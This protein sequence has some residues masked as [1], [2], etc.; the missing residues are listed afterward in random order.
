[1]IV[2][3]LRARR[4]VLGAVTLAR[5][6]PHPALTGDELTLVEDLVHRVALSVDKARLHRETEHIAERL[7][8]SLLPDLPKVDHLTM[9]ARYTP[10]HATA[11]VGGD[12]YD[13][14]VLPTGATTLIIGDVTGH[15]LRAAVAT[16]LLPPRL[17][18]TDGLIERRG[19]SLEHGMTR[20][21]QHAAALAHTHPAELCEELIAGL[22]PHN[23]D[24]VAVLALR[25]PL[26]GQ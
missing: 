15:D 9:A 19:E 24:D 23:T 3:P 25:L 18:Y 6:P 22:A 12:W 2:A 20:L 10:S 13:S 11:E 7:Q 16:E 5:M 14:F 17:L 26:A 8:R 21:R 4:E 1:M